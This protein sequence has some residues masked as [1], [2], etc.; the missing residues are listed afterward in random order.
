VSSSSVVNSSTLAAGVLCGLL[1][2]GCVGLQHAQPPESL[3]P[4]A[5]TVPVAVPPP[6]LIGAS[7]EMPASLVA[8]LVGGIGARV[9]ANEVESTIARLMMRRMDGQASKQS[10]FGDDEES[11]AE[12]VQ[13]SFQKSA[14]TRFPGL[15]STRSSVSAPMGVG[16]GPL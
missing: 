12:V 16:R 5:Q 4:T 2:A 15:A 9:H 3:P 11:S 8:L 10:A 6:S 14:P 13:A 7:I 1:A